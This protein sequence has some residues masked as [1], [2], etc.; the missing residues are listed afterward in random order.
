MQVQHHRQWA[1]LVKANFRD[2]GPG[3]VKRQEYIVRMQKLLNKIE[4]KK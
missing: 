4:F 3:C 2:G 1:P